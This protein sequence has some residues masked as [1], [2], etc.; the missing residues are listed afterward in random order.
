MLFI[1]HAPPSPGLGSTA[2]LDSE[3]TPT[4][5][6][7]FSALFLKPLEIIAQVAMHFSL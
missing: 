7:L 2:L 6:F 3:E 1:T 5:A 4:P